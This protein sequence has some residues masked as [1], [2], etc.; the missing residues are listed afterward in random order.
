MFDLFRSREKSVRYLLGALLTLV[1]LSMV[2]T[3]VPGYGGGWGGGSSSADPTILAEIGDQKVTAMDVRQ[4]LA[5]EKSNIQRG[6]EQF[7]IPIAVQQMVAQR[8][9]AY[10]A[11]RLGMKVT[12]A[13]LANSVRSIIPQL[14][15]NGKFVGNEAYAAFLA[16][17]NFT[18]PQ[19]EENVR[20]AT[21]ETRLETLAL[22]GTI[23]TPSDVEDEYKVRNDKIKIAYFGISPDLFKTKVT[24]SPEEVKAFYD[25]NRTM[26]Q[27]PE[28]RSY[29]VF[30]VEEAKVAETVKVDDATLQKVYNQNQESFRTPERVKVSH[31]L[32]KTTDKSPAE[33]AQIQ[34][35]A[36]DLLKQIKGGAN[37]A[38]L[39]KKYSEDNA[40][41]GGSAAKGGDLDWIVRGQT[42][43]EFE[44]A[45]FSLAP[46]TVSDL[47]KTTY[48]FHILKVFTHEQAHLRAFAEVRDQ[49][50]SEASRAVVFEKM[51]NLADQLRT[52][53][54]KS[55][56]GAEKLAANNNITPVRVEHVA[57]GDPIPEVGVNPQFDEA[58]TGLAKNGVTPVVQI[59]QNKL[60]VAQVTDILPPHP[61][62]FTDVQAKVRD[63]LLGQKAQ[64]ATQNA[65]KEATAKLKSVGGDLAALAKQ[66]GA[67]LKTSELV[68]R[69][70][71]ITGLGSASSVGEGYSR[72]VGD[73]FG[74]IPGATGTFYCKVLEK[75]P[76]DLTALAGSRQALI[77]ELKS[78]RAT[79]RREL[80]GDGVVQAL[81]KEKRLKMYDDNIK[82]LIA[83]YINN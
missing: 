73:V 36:E 69:N 72:N 63:A 17:Q 66:F 42:V 76:A 27:L 56:A 43:P 28:R 46:N 59:G 44:K 58:T 83:S 8:A 29:L 37:F 30:P 70:A 65:I 11:D 54:I 50:A 60:V 35:K 64:E 7:Y 15:E 31:I 71:A 77:Q 82:K 45:A 14:F 79:E 51:Q 25:K 53:L 9:V 22:E 13:D 10:Q 21:L 55:A 23:V 80:F 3:L 18:I 57:P 52:E 41:G 32:L 81:I 2:I 75:Q 20:M 38:E 16:Q 34:K 26:Y 49:I 78:R 40:N 61:A 39:A 12:D 47:V 1:A 5:R 68:N 62:E 74:P 19:F 48:G 67:D 24:V 6:M 33:V 4:F